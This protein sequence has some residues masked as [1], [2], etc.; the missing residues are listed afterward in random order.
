MQPQVGSSPLRKVAS[1]PHPRPGSQDQ[2]GETGICIFQKLPG[3]CNHW[4]CPPLPVKITKVFS[5]GSCDV[6]QFCV[7]ENK[8]KNYSRACGASLFDR[9]AGRMRTT[10]EKWTHVSG[11]CELL[12][13]PRRYI[14]QWQEES[15]QRAG[16]LSGSVTRDTDPLEDLPFT[17]MLP[18]EMR[19]PGEG[20]PLA[21]ATQFGSGRVEFKGWTTAMMSSSPGP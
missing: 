6:A 4:V 11:S 15:A 9:Q 10:R 18:L 12:L 8:F 5:V 2:W 14:I 20:D 19:G 13:V 3:D 7:S 16:G 17:P 21:A 1:R